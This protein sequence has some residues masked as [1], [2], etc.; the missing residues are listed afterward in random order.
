MLPF[1]R[2]GN[3][4]DI[5]DGLAKRLDKFAGVVLTRRGDGKIVALADRCTHCGGPLHQGTLENGCIVCA[6]HGSH[7]ASDG[8]VGVSPTRPAAAYEEMVADG[9]VQIRRTDEPRTPRKNP[10]GR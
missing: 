9:Q 10:V 5:E 3:D 6:R 1:R 4:R 2:N 8:P 7:F